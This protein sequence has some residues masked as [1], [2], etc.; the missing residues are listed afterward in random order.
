VIR[1]L[2]ISDAFLHGSLNEEVYME[3]PKGF[4]DKENPKMMCKLHKAI[5]GLKQVPGTWFHRLFCYLLDIGFTTPLVDTSLVI[6]IT[7]N[8]KVFMLIYMD[9][10]IITGTHPQLITNIVELMQKEFPVEDLGS[11]SLFLGIQVTRSFAKQNMLLTSSI[12]PR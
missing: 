5:Y 10:I 1:Q 2:D 8:I 4:V 3:Q 7:S 9:D 11:L 12:E 6:F